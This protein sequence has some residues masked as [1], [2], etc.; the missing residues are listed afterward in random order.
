MLAVM[1]L[2]CHLCRQLSYQHHSY[3]QRHYYQ[4]QNLENW[5]LEDLRKICGPIG[6]MNHKQRVYT[7]LSS[8]GLVYY[9]LLCGSIDSIVRDSKCFNRIL[10]ELVN[11]GERGAIHKIEDQKEEKMLPL[12]RRFRC[13]NVHLTL[14]VLNASTSTK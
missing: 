8:C 13:N 5:P 14:L 12:T 11:L 2:S 7:R 1:L 10:I 6:R 3:Y 9:D 4:H